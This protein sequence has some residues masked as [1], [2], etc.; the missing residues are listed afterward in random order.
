MGLWEVVQQFLIQTA[1]YL[2]VPG[3]GFV[4]SCAAISDTDTSISR[5][6]WRWVCEELFSNLWYRHLYIQVYLEVDLWEVV[7]QSL[8]QT[9]LYLDVPGGGFVRIVQQS[10]IQTPLYLGAPG[11]GFV[12]S[13]AAISDTDS[14][15]SRCTWR[16][17]CEELCSNLWY[18]Q[19]YVSS[20]HRFPLNIVSPS[21]SQDIIPET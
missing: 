15:I 16:W 12:R 19:L 20:S 10:L 11:G 13:C 18:R 14:S 17:V 5:C 6:T 2:G 8:I 21:S 4:R 7:Q 1:L 9:A 3:G